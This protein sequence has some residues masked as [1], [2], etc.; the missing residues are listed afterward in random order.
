MK[1]RV[2][3]DT[4]T[5]RTTI[6]RLLIWDGR[7]W[8]YECETLEDRLRHPEVKVPKQ[9]C[10]PAA[11][12]PLLITMSERFKRR[13]ALVD[14]VPNFRGIR[15]HAGNGPDDTEGCLLVGQRRDPRGDRILDSLKAYGPLWAKLEAGITDRDGSTIEYVHV[16]VPPAELLAR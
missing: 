11:T 15:I 9:T 13:M 16:T 6:G 4:F 8:A 10:I 1:L 3:R 5:F 2:E 14:R 7:G 12:Y